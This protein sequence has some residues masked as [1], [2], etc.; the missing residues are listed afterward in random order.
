[1]KAADSEWQTSHAERSWK[2]TTASSAQHAISREL[3]LDQM[4]FSDVLYHK[5]IDAD[6]AYQSSH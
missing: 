2:P 6:H 5:T 3:K 1:M 4:D